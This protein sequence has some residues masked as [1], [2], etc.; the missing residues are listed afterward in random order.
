MKFTQ[1]RNKVKMLLTK[2][3]ML[4]LQFVVL[5]FL[6]TIFT[7]LHIYKM[8]FFK[9]YNLLT[10]SQKTLDYLL[11]MDHSGSLWIQNTRFVAGIYGWRPPFGGKMD[12]KGRKLA[13]NNV[14]N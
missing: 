3:N 8:F 6:F 14:R 7:V 2:L 5:I 4:I 11:W 1:V 12:E 9:H 13:L 10:K